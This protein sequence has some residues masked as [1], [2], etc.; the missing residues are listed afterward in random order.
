MSKHLK[1]LAAPR[2][3]SIKRKVAKWTIKPSPGPHP[4]DR[5]VPLGIVVR[6]MLMLCDNRKEAKKIIGSGEIFVDGRPRK[7]LKYPCGLMDVISI[8]K[9]K[10]SYRVLFDRKGRLTLIPIKE[11]EEKWKLCLIKNKTTLKGN[12]RQLNLH[13]GRNIIVERNN[14]K[15]GDVIKLSFEDNKILDVYPME[16]GT[17]ALVIGG[18]HIGEVAKIENIEITRSMQPN[19]VTLVKEDKKFSTIKDYV[20]PIGRDAPVITLPEVKAL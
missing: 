14:F 5:C 19:L 1:R 2:A 15:T 20:F 13:D 3:I 6:D 4:A 16:K 9:L 18:S 7:D 8:P 12:K 17:I 11:D 10:K